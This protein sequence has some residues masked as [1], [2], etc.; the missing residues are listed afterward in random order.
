[1]N[2]EPELARELA[3]YVKKTAV[4]KVNVIPYNPV[5]GKTFTRTERDRIDIFKQI[6]RDHDVNVT[7]RKTMGDDINAAC[8]QLALSSS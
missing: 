7:E 1:V 3:T 6:L 4:T 5:F 2:D 8:G